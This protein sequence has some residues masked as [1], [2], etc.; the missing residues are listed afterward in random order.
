MRV[1]PQLGTL[2]STQFPAVSGRQTRTPRN[3]LHGGGVQHYADTP[4]RRGVWRLE[5]RAVTDVERQALEVFFHQ[6]QGRLNTFTFLDPFQNL[7]SRSIDLSAAEWFAEAPLALTGGAGDPEGGSAAF[8]VA[9]PSPAPLRIYQA[10]NIPA[11]F[12]YSLSVY[13][14]AGT[15]APVALSLVGGSN[16]VSKSFTLSGAWTRHTLTATAGGN[17][18]A[19][20][21]G[22][23]IAAG[24]QIFLFGPQL[25]AQPA[26]SGY[27]PTQT[28]GG[29]YAKARLMQDELVWTTAAPGAHDTRLTIASS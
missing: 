19:V 27:K 23:E 5:Y 17:A 9:N 8:G 4:G 7:F 1:I 29:V 3:R 22:F 12:Q 18:Q 6:V 21:A 15:A 25:E 2:A 28:A 14:R 16:S 24:Q 10:L 11:W 26:P 13:A 20:E